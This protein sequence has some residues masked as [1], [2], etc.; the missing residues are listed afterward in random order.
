MFGTGLVRGRS[1][2]RASFVIAAIVIGLGLLVVS[3]GLQTANA[4][5]G[6]SSR[7]GKV[8]PAAVPS[9]S[10]DSSTVSVGNGHGSTRLRTAVSWVDGLAAG[11][12]LPTEVT[13][14]LALQRPALARIVMAAW[15]DLN[16][17]FRSATT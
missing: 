14:R 3:R 9:A 11:L 5:I 15:R 8:A 17:E 6:A 7:A 4:P 16:P 13:N 10:V 2:T 1:R 12:I